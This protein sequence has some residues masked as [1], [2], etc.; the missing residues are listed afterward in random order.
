M[1]VLVFFAEFWAFVSVNYVTD[2]ILDPN[3][4]ERMRITFNI[5]VLDLPCEF[6]SIDVVDV[7]GTR[8]ED[9][10]VNIN[11]WAID[12]YGEKTGYIGRNGEV[13]RE[14]AHDRHH[15]MDTLEKNGIHAVHIDADNFEQFLQNNKYVF[16][17]WYAPWCIWCQRLEP[18]WEALAQSARG[19]GL[20]VSVVKVDCVKNHDFCINHRVQAFPTLRFYTGGEVSVCI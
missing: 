5:S 14:L 4:D 15:D 18:V 8:K 20:P 2:T 16:V 7:L 12:V 1:M 3:N 13:D 19:D 6:T 10:Q 11:K 17:N 9:V